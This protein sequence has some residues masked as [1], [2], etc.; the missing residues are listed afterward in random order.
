MSTP[1]RTRRLYRAAE[2]AIVKCLRV[3]RNERFAIVTD[4]PCRKIAMALY[5]V[6]QSLTDPILVEMP[7]REIHGMEPPQLVAQLLR[8]C[9]VF[10]IP[11]SRSLS[12]TRARIQACQAG[13]RGATMPGITPSVMI[14]A[15]NADYARVARL[16]NRVADL[17]TR[18]RTARVTS[19]NGTDLTLDLTARPAFSDTGFVHQRGDFSNLPAGEAY[20]APLETRSNGIVVIDGSFAPFGLVPA[21]IRLE[22]KNGR[23]ASIRNGGKIKAIFDQHGPAERT[24][25]EL[26]IGTNH[27]AIV[28][29]NV[30]EDEKALGTVHVA[31]GNNLGF[32]GK[33]R[34]GIH[35]DGIIRKPTLW[36]DKRLIIKNGAF[37]A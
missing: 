11:T 30:L 12:H 32:G 35:L 1:S 33:N 10:I 16:T 31:F 8:E 9:D 21:P 22:V 2:T 14:R 36:L 23:I 25:A 18:A 7:V 13:A 34:A 15:L 37:L 24:L 5:E 19:A 28:T 26:G 6:A 20:A 29:G 4:A 27:E 3:R 17:L